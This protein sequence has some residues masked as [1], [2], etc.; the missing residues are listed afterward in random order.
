MKKWLS[1]GRAKPDNRGESSTALESVTRDRIQSM[2][3]QFFTELWRVGDGSRTRGESP[4]KYKQRVPREV[5]DVL[6][7]S[8]MDQYDICTTLTGDSDMD[9]KRKMTLQVHESWNCSEEVASLR[10]GQGVG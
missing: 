2:S 3:Q 7:K 9:I 6:F 1:R 4:Y 8:F 10:I 5:R